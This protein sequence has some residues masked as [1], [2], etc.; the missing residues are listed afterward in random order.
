M[1]LGALAQTYDHVMIAAPDLTR[2]SYAA[3]LA[4]FVRGTVLVTG[5]GEARSAAASAQLAAMGFRNVVVVEA[6]P[7][8]RAAPVVAA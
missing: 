7:E 8:P 5:E 6:A 2:F 1:I 3:R 4:R